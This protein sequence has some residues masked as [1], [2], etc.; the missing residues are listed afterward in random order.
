MA[1]RSSTRQSRS[2]PAS[3]PRNAAHR[4]S[5]S[6][7]QAR[8][9]RRHPHRRRRRRRSAARA[10]LTTPPVR[11]HHAAGAPGLSRRFH[12]AIGKSCLSAPA[13]SC[14]HAWRQEEHELHQVRHVQIDF[15]R[16][17]VGST[18]PRHPKTT[19]TAHAHRCL[20]TAIAAKKASAN[21][22]NAAPAFKGGACIDGPS[23]GRAVTSTLLP[24]SV[25]NATA[26]W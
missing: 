16:F 21:K 1:G 12:R 14:A 13:D 10:A 18:T 8:D 19:A 4:S 6:R 26:G 23:D 17:H 20:N 25:V 11:N 7:A 15:D 2:P 3:G 9:A 24:C 5:T 22:V